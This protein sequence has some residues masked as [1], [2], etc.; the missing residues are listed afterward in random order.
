MGYSVVF[1]TY[2]ITG[3]GFLT[4][5]VVL[6]KT[7]DVLCTASHCDNLQQIA[8]TT[9][10]LRNFEGKPKTCCDLDIYGVLIYINIKDDLLLN[11]TI[12]SVRVSL[13]WCC[14]IKAESRQTA[15]RSRRITVNQCQDPLS[16][17][18]PLWLPTT[19]PTTNS[20]T[21]CR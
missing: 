2:S 11:P 16:Q 4:K 13:T 3:N 17:C 21:Q 12:K 8:E 10:I 7:Y 5:M 19:Q 1:R 14:V 18:L 6:G 20:A 15:G 9:S